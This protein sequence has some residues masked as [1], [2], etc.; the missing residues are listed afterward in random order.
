MYTHDARVMTSVTG[1][2]W[3]HLRLTLQDD[4]SDAV[5]EIGSRSGTI[6]VDSLD[7]DVLDR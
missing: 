6:F 2:C 5:R 1:D 3:F 7:V 4:V